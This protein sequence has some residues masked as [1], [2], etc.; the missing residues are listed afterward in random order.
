MSIIFDDFKATS[1][2]QEP[3][4][5]Q[6]NIIKP[7]NTR[8]S[9]L[10]IGDEPWNRHTITSS[11]PFDVSVNENTENVYY[12]EFD[13]DSY[14]KKLKEL[15]KS[16]CEE[17]I[18]ATEG[19]KWSKWTNPKYKDRNEKLKLIMYYNNILTFVHN[20]LN[21]SNIMDL[22]GDKPQK[23]VQIVHDL[24]KR[25]RQNITHKHYYLFDIELICY[26]EGKLHGKHIKLYVVSNGKKINVIAIKIIGVISEDN[27]VLYPYMGNDTLNNI[28]FDIFIPE[29][30]IIEKN[31]NIGDTMLAE[32]MD[33]E[34]ENIMY[35][36]L[37]ED[38]DSEAS[39]IN[40]ISYDKEKLDLL[41]NVS[42]SST[43]D[44]INNACKFH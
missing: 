25:Y 37:I 7:Y 18:I 35:R 27:I 9:Y 34:I 12:Y 14:N 3:F 4:I 44:E 13:N 41:N 38:Y 21:T 28:G 30:N 33:L 43:Y 29:G 22:P 39:D 16:N 42:M 19:N 31:K 17:L 20:K 11:I 40:N 23:E 15:F 24:M 26:R 32:N 1:N 5:N 6:D 8:I 2:T 10:N 36:K